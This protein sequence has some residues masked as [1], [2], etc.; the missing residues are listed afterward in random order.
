[1]WII[2]EPITSIMLNGFRMTDPKRITYKPFI[3]YITIYAT[4]SG[5]Q[6]ARRASVIL[7]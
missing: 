5:M 1:M 3:L 2:C 4:M 6:R 7:T